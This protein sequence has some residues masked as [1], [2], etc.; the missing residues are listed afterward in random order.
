MSRVERN[1]FIYDIT[2]SPRTLVAGLLQ[3]P[4]VWTLRAVFR[5]LQFCFETALL[6]AG[7][8]LVSIQ[9]NTVWTA[10]SDNAMPLGEFFVASSSGSPCPVSLTRTNFHRRNASPGSTPSVRLHFYVL[11]SAECRCH[12]SKAIG[13]RLSRNEMEAA[14]W[15]V[16]YV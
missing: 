2:T 4:G 16:V 3:S 11:A 15:L 13:T 14:V 10:S 6:P 1:V 9:D 5:A 7:W 12:R 8:S